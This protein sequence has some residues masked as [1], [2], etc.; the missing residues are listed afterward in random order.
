MEGDV[1]HEAKSLGLFENTE[2]YRRE[3]EAQ[4]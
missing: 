2:E 1:E 3:L 4:S